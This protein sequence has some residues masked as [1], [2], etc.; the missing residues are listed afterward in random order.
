[1]AI[2]REGGVRQ[3]MQHL[4]GR[5]YRRV[6]Y[7]CPGTRL[8]PLDAR[9]ATYAALCREAGQEPEQ[10]LLEPREGACLVTQ[11]GMREAGL[12]AGLLLAARAPQDRPDAVLCHNDLV[13]IGLYHGLRR[14]GLRVPEDIAVAGFDG[15]DEGLCLDRPLTTVVSPGQRLVEA[16]L[17]I[18]T[19]RLGAR[20]A[21]D[22]PPQ[23][24][25]LPSTLRV[26]NTT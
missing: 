2:D 3:L 9:F 5:G 25:V 14:A 8:Q 16:A 21:A 20:D 4:W 17:D 26:G 24:I 13:A 1:V 7:L 12:E 11:A 6:A 19:R 10:I 23:Q 15:I 22:P 18:L